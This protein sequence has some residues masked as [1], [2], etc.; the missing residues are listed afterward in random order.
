MCLACSRIGAQTKTEIKSLFKFSM[1]K[2]YIRTYDNKII[3][4]N[5]SQIN[6]IID[7]ALVVVATSVDLSCDIWAI[8][9]ERDYKVKLLK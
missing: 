6:E 7:N 8:Q 3:H 5:E 4:L 9:W 1:E 2:T